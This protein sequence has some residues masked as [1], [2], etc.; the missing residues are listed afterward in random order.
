MEKINIRSGQKNIWQKD[1]K[2]PKAL[3]FGSCLAPYI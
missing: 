2:E 3:L 1:R